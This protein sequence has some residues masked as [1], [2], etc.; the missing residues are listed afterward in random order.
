MKGT[1]SGLGRKCSSSEMK[2][3]PPAQIQPF[4]KAVSAFF[5]HFFL[6]LPPTREPRTLRVKLADLKECEGSA[7]HSTPHSCDP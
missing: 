5:S 4:K 6:L 2:K 7:Q 3:N 1:S